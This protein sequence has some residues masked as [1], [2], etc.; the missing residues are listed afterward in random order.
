M[1]GVIFPAGPIAESDDAGRWIMI[2]DRK[3]RSQVEFNAGSLA[4]SN[5]GS[6]RLSVSDIASL[7]PRPERDLTKLGRIA[8]RLA[9]EPWP[10]VSR[11]FDSIARS[12][13]EFGGS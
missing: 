10:R 6:V 3:E 5:P 4:E 2:R 11:T 13:R 12:T 8:R 1:I 7:P 9:T